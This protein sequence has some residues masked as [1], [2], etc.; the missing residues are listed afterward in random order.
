[1]PGLRPSSLS[2]SMFM[3]TTD[4]L[5]RPVAMDRPLGDQQSDVTSPAFSSRPPPSSSSGFW[6]SRLHTTLWLGLPH[7]VRMV[8]AG[9]WRRCRCVREWCECRV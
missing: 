4:P 7:T 8:R 6:L 2:C 5:L 9:N 1:M 3:S